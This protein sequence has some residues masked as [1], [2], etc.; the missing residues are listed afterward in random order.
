MTA[1]LFDDR[2]C[3][4]G[5]GPLWHPARGQ[6]FW[7]DIL[8]RR[9]LTR[10]A[11]GPREWDM[12]EFAS[13]AGWIDEETLLIASESGLFRFDIATGRR[14]LLAPLEADQPDTRSNDGR[15]DPMG[16]FWIGTM[17][18]AAQT[19]R[20]AIYRFAGGELRRLYGSIT[21]PNAISFAP[22]GRRAYFADTP[23]HR[24]MT[25]TLD[26]AGWPDAE[27][28]VF[29]DLSREELYPDGAVTDA[30]GAMWV[31]QWGAGRVARYRADGTF[32]RAVDV[33]AHQ[34]TC[35]AFGG[36]AFDRLFVTSAWEGLERQAPVDGQTVEVSPEAL[37][38]PEPRVIL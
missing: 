33:P 7:F 35:P 24:V 1:S 36:E 10:D 26:A 16:G 19:G 12:G 28:Q 27:P 20:G 34:S 18:K 31:A 38:R 8:G 3:E 15:A 17:G 4:L 25:V 9:L 23:T 13:A 2:R 5:E 6:L 37:G 30:E 29:L 11:G 22:D 32:D 14:T 21:I